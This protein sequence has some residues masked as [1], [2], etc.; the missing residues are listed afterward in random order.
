MSFIW[1]VRT[2]RCG[3]GWEEMWGGGDVGRMGGGDVG[4]DGRRRCG[5]GWEEEM[6]GGGEEMQG[7]GG[8][9]G[10][11]RRCGGGRC[12][13][14]VRLKYVAIHVFLTSFLMVQKKSCVSQDNFFFVCNGRGILSVAYAGFGRGGFHKGS[15]HIQQGGMGEHCKLPHHSLG[16]SP[17]RFA[18]FAI[19]KSQNIT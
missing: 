12:G 17:S 6:W 2:G 1:L 18:T 4:E 3:G 9:A 10:G 13:E 5:G 14:D 16:W 15:P 7:G 19:F 8:D 11:R